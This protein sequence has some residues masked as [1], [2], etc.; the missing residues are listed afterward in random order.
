MPGADSTPPTSGPGELARWWRE[1]SDLDQLVAELVEATEARSLAAA[2]AALEELASALEGHF[3]VE[4]EVYFP[5][6]S[7]LRPEFAASLERA[8]LAHTE[9]RNRFDRMRGHLEDGDRLGAKDLLSGALD[10]F[11]IHEEMEGSLIADLSAAASP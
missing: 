3:T 2:T 1:H 6:V 10:L 8:R 5:L 9:L 4:E 11:R 7:E